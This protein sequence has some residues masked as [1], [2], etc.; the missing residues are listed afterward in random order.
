MPT[1]THVHLHTHAHGDRKM[2]ELTFKMWKVFCTALDPKAQPGAFPPG[3]PTEGCFRPP[4]KTFCWVK[5]GARPAGRKPEA[6]Q[7]PKSLGVQSP[8]SAAEN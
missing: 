7:T 1:H 4:R 2:A 8:N 5:A 6:P 3:V